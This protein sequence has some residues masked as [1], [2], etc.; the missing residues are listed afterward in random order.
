MR[1]IG[2]DQSLWTPA[3]KKL[4]DFYNF[5]P[6][7]PIYRKEFG[8]YVLDRWIAEG[9]LKPYDAVPDYDAYL[10]GV[11]GMDENV[12]HY[13]TGI[14]DCEAGMF[15]PFE[16][17]V[18]EDRGD[19]ELV[20]DI[21]GRSVLYFKGRRN[22]FMPEYIDHPVK[23]MDSWQRLVKWRLDPATPGRDE[24]IR[25]ELEAAAEW[26]K[27]GHVISQLYGGG[28]MYLRSLIGGEALLYMFYDDPALIHDCM[29]TWFELADARI[30]YHQ[31]FV[32]F[33]ELLLDEDICYNVGPLISPDMIREFLFP[34]YQQLITNMKARSRDPGRRI[35]IQ[36]ATDGNM[37][38]VMDL[39]REIGCDYFTPFEV[40]SGCDVVEVGRK[41]PDVLMAGGIDKR[42]IAQGGDAIKRH[43]DYIMPTMRAR[44]GYIPTC[45]H[46]VPEEVSFE[47]Y[48]R[49][50]ELLN[51]YC[52]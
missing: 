42:L 52:E 1:S 15:P 49:Y 46:G 39:Y 33:D 21:A 23:D 31:Q 18:L 41:Y 28:Y 36:L 26:Q 7:A 48:V 30:A 2:C 51:A 38:A 35:R 8:Y 6:G 22:G 44:G 4:R 14:G 19:H 50:R 16:V 5:T 13:V 11:F 34:Y 32:D 20:Q 37:P 45:D 43:L 12:F 27:K 17:K 40:A 3:V 24:A 10:R 29:K 9:Y 25:P 47:N